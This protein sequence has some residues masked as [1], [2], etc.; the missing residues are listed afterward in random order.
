MFQERQIHY[1]V[2]HPQYNDYTL[3]NDIALLRLESPVNTS[4]YVPACLPGPGADYVDKMV[5]VLGWGRLAESGQV[6]DT[7]QEL[8]IKVVD[9]ATCAS[10]MGA[11]SIFPA[12][13]ICAGGELGKD[14]CQGDSG[15]PLMYNDQERWE[16]TGLT[17]WGIG[18]ARQGLYGVY[19]EVTRKFVRTLH[20]YK[21]TFICVTFQIIWIGS[22]TPFQTMSKIVTLIVTIFIVIDRSSVIEYSEY[23]NPN[24]VF[25]C[26]TVGRHF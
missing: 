22:G 10:A 20:S 16:L 25:I 23:I 13:M 17:S 11:S 2:R 3:E 19:A 4:V 7:L 12:Q 5:W 15:G 14:G 1:R 26:D 6:A 18:C 24:K 9:D 8:E 21:T